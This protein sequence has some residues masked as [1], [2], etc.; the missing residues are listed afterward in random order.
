MARGEQ[1][2]LCG[3]WDKDI[4]HCFV[5]ISFETLRLEKL[6]EPV[7]ESK[8]LYKTELC[9]D[10]IESFQGVAKS[11]NDV[12]KSKYKEVEVAK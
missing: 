9:D 5:F 11:V 7:W 12:L 2:N 6:S 1:C 3:K 10:C 4:K 8:T